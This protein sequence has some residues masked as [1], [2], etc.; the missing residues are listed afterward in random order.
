MHCV[1]YVCRVWMA[2]SVYLLPLRT[3]VIVTA[4]VAVGLGVSMAA[5]IQARA[6][7][8]PTV[9]AWVVCVSAGSVAMLSVMASLH[10]VI[11]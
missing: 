11:E 10:G 5:A 9:S 2:R 1:L 7:G 8:L 6:Q 4:A 3:A